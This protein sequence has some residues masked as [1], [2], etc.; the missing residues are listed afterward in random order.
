MSNKVLFVGSNPSTK[1]LDNSAMHESTR[2]RKT[3][4]SWTSGID[5][6]VYFCNVVDHITENN[7]PISR[8]QIIA[9]LEN[10][11]L[12]I[13]GFNCDHVVALGKSAS[14]ALHLVSIDHVE[15]PHP[16]GLN[17][18]LNDKGVVD[19]I[20]NRLRDMT[21]GKNNIEDNQPQEGEH[22]G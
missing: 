21:K 13:R 9:N 7:K 20:K 6:D 16:S 19:G 10:L 3:L 17:R 4:N 8:K 18:K 5:I 15:I 2:S 1:S 22:H 11:L 12:K 14:Y